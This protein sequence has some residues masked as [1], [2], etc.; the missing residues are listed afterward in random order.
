MSWLKQIIANSLDGNAVR[1][2][3]AVANEM[4]TRIETAKEAIR[5]EVAQKMFGESDVEVEDEAE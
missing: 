3:E 5:M 1:V 2:R 4:N